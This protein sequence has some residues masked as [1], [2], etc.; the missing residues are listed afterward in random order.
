MI[1]NNPGMVYLQIRFQQMTCSILHVHG[2]YPPPP[3]QYMFVPI[4]LPQ[5]THLPVIGSTT[6]ALSADAPVLIYFN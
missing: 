5:Y 3:A 4:N 2:C 6:H 1:I